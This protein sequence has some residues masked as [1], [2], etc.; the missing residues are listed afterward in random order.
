MERIPQNLRLLASNTDQLR[1]SLGVDGS[2]ISYEQSMEVGARYLSE[3]Y[4]DKF[5]DKSFPLNDDDKKRWDLS[6]MIT[7]KGDL[8]M[9]LIRP[10][11]YHLQEE[12]LRFLKRN[13]FDVVYN[14]DKKVSPEQY[15]HMYRD[16]FYR[17]KA[18]ESL[19]TRTMV[20]TG[21]ISR[22]VVFKSLEGTDKPLPDLFCR[23]FKGKEGVDGEDT[24]RGGVVLRE[25]LRLGF[26]ELNDSQ[27]AKALDPIY[28]LRNIVERSEV[29]KPHSHLPK[30][31]YLLKYNAVSVHVP[32]SDEIVRDLAVLND[33]S[34]LE[35]IYEKTN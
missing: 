4:L 20:Y 6:Q 18:A 14:T 32:D 15:W 25:A 12:V 24:V 22:L 17:E 30:D 5:E 28:A 29:G 8:G 35:D 1:L 3:N 9:L 31:R 34:C 33:V 11:M 27:I 23:D 16:V 19:P 26:N 2:K 13:R 10:E 7:E 21:G